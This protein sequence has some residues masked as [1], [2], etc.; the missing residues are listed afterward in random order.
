MGP[1]RGDRPPGRVVSL[2]ITGGT[3]LNPLPHPSTLVL[4]D[5]RATLKH[6]FP[7]VL[8]GKVI[9]VLLFIGLLELAGTV[10]AL[11]GA[12]GFSLAALLRRMLRRQPGSGLL[13]LTTVGLLARTVAALATGSLVIYFLQPTVST[14]LVGLAFLGSVLLGRPL[15]ERLMVDVCPMADETRA[16]PHLRRFLSHLSLW[17]AFTSA[18]NFGVTLWVLLNESAT[19][20]VLVKSVLG[21]VT[22]AITLGVGFLWFR[23]SMA[24]AG[25][26]VVFATTR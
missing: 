14:A 1:A 17:W 3:I 10:P 15:A 8:E 23:M 25:T 11:L 12:L 2:L 4:P 24:R 7:N 9:P 13:V 20:F 22:T 19:T 16:H 18:V 26:T 21:P 6:A 5:F